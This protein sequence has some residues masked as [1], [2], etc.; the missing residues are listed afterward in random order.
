MRRLTPPA[1]GKAAPRTVSVAIECLC[2][3]T[4]EVVT[5][6]FF[7]SSSRN[8]TP[9][10]CLSSFHL[11]VPPASVCPVQSVQSC[12]VC[13]HSD[14]MKGRRSEMRH[15]SLGPFEMR[16]RAAFPGMSRR[17]RHSACP[18]HHSP[19]RRCPRPSVRPLIID[20]IIPDFQERSTIRPALARTTHIIAEQGPSRRQ[21]VHVHV[22]VRVPLPGRRCGQ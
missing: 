1:Q 8:S 19:A 21:M 6:F 13:H 10:A 4:R 9:V 20:L 15:P 18:V 17:R 12:P 22:H 5:C 2:G 16:N 14:T 11:A 3:F 7:F